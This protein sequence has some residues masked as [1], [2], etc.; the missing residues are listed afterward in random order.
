MPKHIYDA[1]EAWIDINTFVEIDDDGTVG[2][3][4]TFDSEVGGREEKDRI[5]WFFGGW[6]SGT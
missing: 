5:Y 2:A 4:N 1:Y 3:C 6:Y